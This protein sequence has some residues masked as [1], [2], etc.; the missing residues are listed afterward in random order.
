[1]QRVAIV[2]ASPKPERYSHRAQLM[3]AEYGHQPIPVSPRGGE[4]LGLP[5]VKHV[6]EIPGEL[7]SVTLYVSPAHQ[8]DLLPG[9]MA[10]RP[11]RVIFNP[12]TESAESQAA[13]EAA[14][15]PCVQAC[16]L[17][18]LRTGVFEDAD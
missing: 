10:K 14:G 17:V 11:G 12:G 9:I 7:D 6:E 5:V 18:M 16:T 13:L 15:I 2:G 8:P 1:M 3:L 4:I